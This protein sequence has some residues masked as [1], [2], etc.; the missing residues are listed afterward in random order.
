MHQSRHTDYGDD[1]E[2]TSHAILTTDGSSLHT[3]GALSMTKLGIDPARF[4]YATLCGSHKTADG[5]IRLADTAVIIRAAELDHDEGRDAA[6]AE[7]ERALTVMKA[8][9]LVLV[10]SDDDDTRNDAKSYLAYHVFLHGC[11]KDGMSADDLADHLR[12]I[13]A[14]NPDGMTTIREVVDDYARIYG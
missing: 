4:P 12:E 1:E 13:Y 6:E 8:G 7:I 10:A 2:C 9:G 3:A 14:D 5:G 11:H